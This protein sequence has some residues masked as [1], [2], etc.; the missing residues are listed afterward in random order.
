VLV[1]ERNPPTNAATHFP[2]PRSPPSSGNNP[3]QVDATVSAEVEACVKQVL[4][5][6]GRIDGAANCVGACPTRRAGGMGGQKW[7]DIVRRQCDST[8]RSAPSNV[9]SS[10]SLLN[11]LDRSEAR[12]RYERSRVRADTEDKFVLLVFAPAGV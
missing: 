3:A 7:E 6:F 12:T 2:L 8:P 11:R 10:P 4:A 1:P 9:V 5:K